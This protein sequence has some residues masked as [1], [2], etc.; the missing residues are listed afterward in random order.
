MR[1]KSTCG[2]SCSICPATAA[3]SMYGQTQTPAGHSQFS[4]AGQPRSRFTCS[5]EAQD[6]QTCEPTLGLLPLQLQT[7]KNKKCS[8]M[9]HG[10]PGPNLH[11]DIFNMT[12]GSGSQRSSAAPSERKNEFK[13]LLRMSGDRNVS[14]RSNHGPEPRGPSRPRMARFLHDFGGSTYVSSVW[15]HGKWLTCMS[16]WELWPG[17]FQ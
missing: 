17:W 7:S 15:N 12:K 13:L 8:M 6:L 14:P 10:T 16:A 1:L 9:F 4:L 3:K 5:S 2:R 11:E